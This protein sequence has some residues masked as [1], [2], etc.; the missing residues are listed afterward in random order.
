MS[1]LV[2]SIVALALGP[3][4]VALAGARSWVLALVDGFVIVTIGGIALIHILP[5]AL[6]SCGAWAFLG[7]AAGLFG[8][9][10]LERREHA[11][12]DDVRGGDAAKHRPAM[13]LALLGIA[14]HAFLDGSA[15][16]EH[17]DAHG[18][19]HAHGGSELLALAV[20]LHRIPEGLAIWWLVRPRPGGTRTALAALSIVAVATVLGSR[21]GDE[22]AHGTGAAVF[23][24]VQAVVAGSLLHVVIHHAPPSVAW[25]HHH[26]HASAG[27]RRPPA[28][29][30]APAGGR[31]GGE[32]A[33]RARS[34]YASLGAEPDP[35]RDRGI[36]IAPALGAA[37]GVALL[38]FVSTS[39]P[40]AQ[41]IAHEIA[42]G[43]TFVTLALESA[44]A[45]VVAYVAS[46]LVHAFLP[47]SVVSWLSRGG[48][49]SH[50]L[51]GLLVGPLL[52]V[53]SCG[54][55]P[56]YRSM[57]ARG[58]PRAAA[59]TLLVAAPEL[60]LATFL[61]SWSL[62]GGTFTLVRGAAAVLTAVAVG[63][64]V[65]RLARRRAPPDARAPAPSIA[66]PL[67]WRARLW[68]GV[69]YGLGDTVDHTTPWI[70][71]GLA[72]AAFAE[73]LLDGEAVARVAS[74]VEVPAFAALGIPMYVCASGAT[75]LVAVLLHKGVSP[76][77]AIAFLLTGPATN[78][79]TF[80]VLR[81][82]HGRRLAALFAAA[83]V[84]VP[85]ALG[86]IVN[87][88]L[89]RDRPETLHVA[90]HEPATPAQIAS[91][92]ALGVLVA[93]SL[94]RHGPRHMVAQLVTTRAH[95]H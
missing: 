38:L 65:T 31:D 74:W 10:L 75:P 87:V 30:E 95:D 78:L 79:T 62:L 54:V 94:V 37:F 40:T 60:G 2:L 68:S 34:A 50:S 77:A 20:V 53:C 18:H 56:L 71:M 23:S 25:T 49:L 4:V 41:Q 22:L 7:A 9:M 33:A 3:G 19:A 61:V 44:P 46:G 64:G 70:M 32:A 90:A 76:G 29:V 43:P 39:H 14:M 81:S 72:L 35:H 15:F 84:A 73:P 6:L 42:M 66:P 52:P 69:R 1:L 59:L 21:V 13:A 28:H 93:I 16:A 83:M 55:L 11:H 17:D 5:H 27:R 67:P 86:W 48:P 24:F 58:A 51:R 91:L 8:P 82:M 45:L 80:G 92:V 12:H 26:H 57:V 36:Q 47:R 88:A 85:S 63:Y 89:P